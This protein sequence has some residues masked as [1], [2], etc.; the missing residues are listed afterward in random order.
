MP[1]H[2][3]T[4]APP[5]PTLTYQE[6]KDGPWPSPGALHGDDY[7]LEYYPDAAALPRPEAQTSATCE[8]DVMFA[9]PK[10]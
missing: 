4:D 3:S 5:A 6:K 9:V 10:C 7:P 8:G 2:G 1:L